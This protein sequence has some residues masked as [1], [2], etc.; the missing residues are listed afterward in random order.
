MPEQTFGNC[1]TFASAVVSWEE[2]DDN[3]VQVSRL[4]AAIRAVDGE[5]IERVVKDDRSYSRALEEALESFTAAGDVIYV[6]ELGEVSGVRGGFRM[7][8]AGLG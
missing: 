6:Y 5:Y 8:E 1:Y 3:D 2:G 7:G 4:R